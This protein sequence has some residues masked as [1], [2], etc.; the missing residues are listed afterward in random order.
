MA[1]ITIV[2]VWGIK[3][4]AEFSAVMVGIKILVLLFHRYSAVFCFAVGHGYKL[5]SLPTSRM[6]S[7]LAGAAVVFFAYIGS[8]RFQLSRRRQEQPDRPSVL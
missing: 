8:T 6:A 5:A 3:E 4:S 1:L 7:T 2:L